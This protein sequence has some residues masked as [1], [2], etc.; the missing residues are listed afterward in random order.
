[1]TMIDTKE[2]IDYFTYQAGYA[3]E[4]SVYRDSSAYICDAVTEIADG[5]T[6]IYY[7]DIAKFI[8]EN[9]EAVHDTIEEF[10]WDGCG[11]DL[12]KAG[13]MAE[14]Q[15]IEQGIYEN[16]VDGLLVCAY[17]FL[18]YDLNIDAIPE[19][20]DDAIFEWCKEAESN[21]RMDDIPDKLREWL[22]EHKGECVR[23][24]N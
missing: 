17:N 21:D 14:Y 18:Y 1:M 2:Q 11:G 6:S 23:R 8:A 16:L 15:V 22:E 24:E 12:Y 7:S 20:L 9:V 3:A 5:A 13:Q 4:L 19:E 10:G